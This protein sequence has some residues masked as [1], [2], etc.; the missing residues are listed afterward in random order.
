MWVLALFLG[1]LIGYG[2]ALLNFGFR[3]DP[4][5]YDEELRDTYQAGLD[6]GRMIE[7]MWL[8]QKLDDKLDE[9]NQFW[10]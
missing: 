10:N 3:Q 5:N 7:A 8:R 9:Q 2:F 6:D 1:L 4:T